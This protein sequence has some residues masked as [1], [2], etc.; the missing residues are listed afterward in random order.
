ME[1]EDRMW[2]DLEPAQPLLIG[3]PCCVLHVRE[4]DAEFGVMHPHSELLSVTPSQDQGPGV[5]GD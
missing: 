3:F 1:S 5:P 4:M 2:K